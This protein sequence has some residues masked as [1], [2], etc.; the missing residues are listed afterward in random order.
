[1]PDNDPPYPADPAAADAAW[2][3]RNRVAGRPA[4]RLVAERSPVRALLAVGVSVAL[5]G[6]LWTVR[7]AGPLSLILIPLMA[8]YVVNVYL[9]GGLNDSPL[10]GI[11]RIRREWAQ[12]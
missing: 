7:G 5:I 10:A 1:M 4:P 2:A 9:G 6:L 3:G 11:D 12:R 8:I